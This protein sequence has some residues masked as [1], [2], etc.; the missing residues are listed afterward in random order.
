VP[1]HAKTVTVIAAPVSPAVNPPPVTV[2][3]V[4]LYADAA[5]TYPIATYIVNGNQPDPFRV[6]N[7]AMWFT[8]TTAIGVQSRFAAVFELGI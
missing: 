5:L 8:V 4:T 2:A 7:G 1:G 3:Y 6:P